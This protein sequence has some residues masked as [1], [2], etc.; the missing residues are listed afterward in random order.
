[1][2][3][4]SQVPVHSAREAGWSRILVP[5][6]WAFLAIGVIWLSVLFTAI[7]GPDIE[8]RSAAGDFTHVPSV[9]VVAFFAFL[10]TWAIAAYAFR[11]KT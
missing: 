11:R 3:V 7:Y 6:L 4:V 10:A 9:V 8:N 2:S 1:M 5:E